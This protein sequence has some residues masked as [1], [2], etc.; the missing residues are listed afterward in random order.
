MH[1]TWINNLEETHHCGFNGHSYN[2]FSCPKQPTMVFD[3]CKYIEM[4]TVWAEKAAEHVKS[5]QF[6]VL[7][8]GMLN[9]E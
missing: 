3:S 6:C 2:G 4:V 5:I 9:I 1:S 7:I 8:Q